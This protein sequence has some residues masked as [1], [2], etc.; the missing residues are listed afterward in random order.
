[1]HRWTEEE[2]YMCCELYL[3]Y[4]V[5]KTSSNFTLEGFIDMLECRLP[6]DIPRKSI[7]MKIA[8]IKQ[9]CKEYGVIGCSES[10]LSNYSQQSKK[11]FIKALHNWNSRQSFDDDNDLDYDLN[12]IYLSNHSKRKKKDVL[13]SHQIEKYNNFE[14]SEFI[15]GSKYNSN[16]FSSD[17]SSATEILIIG[18][19]IIAGF[20]VLCYA[21]YRL[22]YLITDT[23]YPKLLEILQ[24]IY[25]NKWY[26][27]AGIV[28]FVVGCYILYILL[29]IFF[30]MLLE[31]LEFLMEVFIYILKILFPI[32]KYGVYISL[33]IGSIYAVYEYIQS[34]N[35]IKSENAEKTD[36]EDN[37]VDTTGNKTDSLKIED[38]SENS[39]NSEDTSTTNNTNNI[40]SEDIPISDML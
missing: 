19:C 31:I 2:D 28:G 35:D 23:I 1:M 14:D 39:L 21:L 26:I 15:S 38:V 13:S 25:D 16:N 40:I 11:M 29:K 20:S 24:M 27:L 36:I 6:D 33:F 7:G 30:R 32:V 22:Y 3:K 5:N 4:F 18:G 37:S 9:L 34:P 10:S 12:K 8:N 17:S